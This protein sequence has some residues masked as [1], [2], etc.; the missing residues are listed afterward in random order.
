MPGSRVAPLV[1]DKETL[2]RELFAA[3]ANFVSERSAEGG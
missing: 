2:K 3:I 1:W